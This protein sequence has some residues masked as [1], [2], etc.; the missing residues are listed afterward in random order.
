MLLVNDAQALPSA[1]EGQLGGEDLP[2]H[3]AVGDGGLARPRAGLGQQALV[4]LSVA[5]PGLVR[6]P[7]NELRLD[8]ELLNSEVQ[9]ELRCQASVLG[10]AV[11]LDLVDLDDEVPGP[12]WWR[13]LGGELFVHDDVELGAGVLALVLG[14]DLVDEELRGGAGGLL[15]DEHLAVEVAE[16]LAVESD[17]EEPVESARLRLL[18][19]D[20]ALAELLQLAV[21]CHRLAV[22]MLALVDVCHE[23]ANLSGELEEVLLLEEIHSLGEELEEAFVAH[24]LH[25][26]LELCLWRWQRHLLADA[27][28]NP[29]Q[30]NE[31]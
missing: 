14:G 22:V 19:L 4:R 10:I 3:L 17:E 11:L 5:R 26:A 31:I 21:D 27:R 7:G 24:S 8:D 9:L 16:L 2:D 25:S 18:H 12:A 20:N 15:V 23:P 1:W 6:H 30:S 28:T 29:P 13:R